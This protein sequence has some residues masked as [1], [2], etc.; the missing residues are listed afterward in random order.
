MSVPAEPPAVTVDTT[1]QLS[2][3]ATAQ[4]HALVAAAT[5]I[6]QVPP[7]SE[8]VT[9]HLR[10]GG[11]ARSRTF[12]AKLDGR[13][14]GY[15]HLDITDEVEGASAE[16]VVDPG[17]RRR[18]AG[19]ALVRAMLDASPDRQLRLWAHGDHPAAAALAASL[20]FERVRSLW[21]MRRSLAEP[22][23]DAALPNGVVVRIFVPGQDEQNWVALNR[24][25][26]ADHPEQG[27][28]TIE[29]LRLRM[30]EQWFDPA[31]FFLAE[32]AGRLVGFHWTKIHG[33][34]HGAEHHGHEPI[35]EIYVI[36]VDPSEQGSGLGTALSVIGLA[37]LRDKG[38][39]EAMLYV[40]ESNTAAIRVYEKLG[41]SHVDTDVMFRHPA[42]GAV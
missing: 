6:D 13:I 28:W 1:G 30:C 39:S 12:L 38:L 33:G 20:G 17:N 35:G 26:F 5:E 7:L 41:F 10:Y 23:P 40:E 29:D 3:Q 31:G 11:D 14:V 2:A 27:K 24:R 21:Q 9:L 32:R 4:V 16:V 22:W 37:H 8:H 15:G 34:R 19:R 42:A 25:A 36:G 18:G